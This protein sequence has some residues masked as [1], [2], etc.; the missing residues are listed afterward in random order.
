M[1]IYT[2]NVF[3]LIFHHFSQFLF[4]KDL[5]VDT[6]RILRQFSAYLDSWGFLGIR[7]ASSW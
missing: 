2:S 6:N 4:F 3:V 7:I 5:K 1:K